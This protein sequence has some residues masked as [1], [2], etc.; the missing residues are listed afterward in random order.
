[1]I[2][3]FY[4]KMFVCRNGVNVEGATHKEVVDLIRSGDDQL[5]LTGMPFAVQQVFTF[6]T[7]N[8]VAAYKPCK[9]TCMLYRWL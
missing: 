5:S 4:L 7:F 6:I 2:V 8:I 3:L 9:V 1:M